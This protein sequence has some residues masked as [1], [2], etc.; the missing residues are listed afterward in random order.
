MIR[1][2]RKLY[3]ARARKDARAL[4]KA[5]LLRN[6]HDDLL[7]NYDPVPGLVARGVMS[8]EPPEDGETQ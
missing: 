7:E 6:A 5:G 3:L 1:S 4:A 8:D 2:W